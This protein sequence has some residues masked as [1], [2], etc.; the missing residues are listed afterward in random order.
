MNLTLRNKRLILLLFQKA[1]VICLYRSSKNMTIAPDSYAFVLEAD[2]RDVRRWALTG[3][4]PHRSYL[5]RLLQFD[6]EVIQHW[7]KHNEAHRRQISCN[8]GIET[9]QTGKPMIKYLEFYQQYLRIERF[10]K[11]LI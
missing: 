7:V 3:E 8:P 9:D 2:Y 4:T 1:R 10:L 11:Q 6:G 5:E